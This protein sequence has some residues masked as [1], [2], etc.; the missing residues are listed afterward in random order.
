[1]HSDTSKHT[2]VVIK[3]FGSLVFAKS[4]KQRIVTK[5]STEAELVALDEAATFVPWIYEFAEELKINVVVPC[6]IYQDN[7]STIKLAIKGSGCFKRNKHILNR[8]FWVHR[9]IDIGAVRL[10]YLPTEK[11]IAD[12]LTKPVTGDQFFKLRDELVH[13]VQ[14]ID[15]EALV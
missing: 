12:I 4:G 15:V 3:L 7:Q 5:S 9:L 11:M 2:G 6:I 10:D 13:G 8:Y 1:V 14:D